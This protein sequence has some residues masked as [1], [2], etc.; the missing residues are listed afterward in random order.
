MLRKEPMVLYTQDNKTERN[1][2]KCLITEIHV[3]TLQINA[4][5]VT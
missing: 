3:P 2:T 4:V 1:F 5:N